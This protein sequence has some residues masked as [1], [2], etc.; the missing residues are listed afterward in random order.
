V[1]NYLLYTHPK[2]IDSEKGMELRKEVIRHWEQKH[3]R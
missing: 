1:D 3:G 2:K